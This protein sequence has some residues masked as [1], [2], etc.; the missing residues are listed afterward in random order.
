MR[1]SRHAVLFFRV[2]GGGAAVGAQTGE[3]G[4]IA[5]VSGDGSDVAIAQSGDGSGDRT[6]DSGINVAS[7][8]RDV[9]H[10]SSNNGRMKGQTR[11]GS[12]F[13]GQP[14]KNAIFN[15]SQ[16]P[17]NAQFLFI[18]AMLVALKRASYGACGI[19]SPGCPCMISF[20]S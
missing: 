14:F 18:P 19:L 13:I 16:L 2:A 20:A 1:F 8:I 6:R 3:S 9:R 17:R 5:V 4:G 7:T 11:R 12:S 10:C 15:I